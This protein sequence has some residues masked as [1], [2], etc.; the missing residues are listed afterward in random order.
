ME[1][2]KLF[3]LRLGVEYSGQGGKK[4]GI[5]AMPSERVLTGMASNIAGI[6]ESMMSLINAM[7][8]EMPQYV[9]ADIRNRTKF[10]YLMIP[11]L[12]QFGWDLNANSPW[13][14]YVNAGPFLSFL[15]G[16]KQVSSGTDMLYLDDTKTA[17]VWNKLIPGIQDEVEDR[18]PDVA[19][20]LQ[21]PFEFGSMDI[22]GELKPVNFGFTGNVG[23]S[24]QYKRN[25]FFVEAGGNYGLIR[26]QKNT[27]NGSNRIGAG[28]IMLGY[29]FNLIQ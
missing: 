12:A 5:Q 27:E 22:T 2:N 24:Y 29:S 21:S 9:Y 13:R 3:S 10:D 14:V 11:V 23:L 6:D 28:T 4:D 1:F 26:V 8:K 17:S 25:R 18:L 16:G 19:A 7:S 20:A 15:M